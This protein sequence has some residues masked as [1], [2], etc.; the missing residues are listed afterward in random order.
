M[1]TVDVSALDTRPRNPYPG[2]HFYRTTADRQ[3]AKVVLR[4]NDGPGDLKLR[5][6]L[7]QRRLEALE[8]KRIR[9]VD[10]TGM[11]Y[12]ERREAEFALD[13]RAV[14]TVL[15]E[16]L[17]ELNIL[18]ISKLAE[19]N[20]DRVSMIVGRLAAGGLAIKENGRCI[21]GGRSVAIWITDAGR[22]HL[23]ELGR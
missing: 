11:T 16:A 6:E 1:R 13:L 9:P 5:A 3:P 4:P 14:L 12:N 22:E 8:A 23:R 15:D 20:T 21:R 2:V 7:A 10:A 19:I 18:D 17:I